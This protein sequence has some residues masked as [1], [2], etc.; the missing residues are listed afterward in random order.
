[1]KKFLLFF[2]LFVSMKSFSQ[3]GVI[4][5][6]VKDSL[7]GVALESATVTILKKDSSLVNYQLSDE[8]GSFQLTKLPV[9]T[10]LILNIT[11]AGF[12]S[13]YKN[14][15]L[16]S[17]EHNMTALL[18]P[19]FDDSLNVTVTAQ[20]PI[21]MNG[22]TL[23]IN[24]AA[25][26]MGPN[27][28]VEDLLTAVPGITV[29]SDGSITLNGKKIPS[30]LVDGKPFMGSDDARI[31]TQNL[32]KD[33]IDKIQVYQE[34]D[35]TLKP[36]ERR[37]KDSLLTMNIKLK[38]N[39][40]T[41]YFGKAAIGYGTTDRFESDLSF[42]MY[43]KKTSFGIGGGYNNINK[44]IENLKEMFQNN[45]YRNYNPNLRN[46]GNFNTEGINRYHSIG[47]AFT[48]N[49]IETSN[50]RQNDRITVNYTKSGNNRYL[51][52]L[53]L[54]NRTTVDNPQLIEDRV[55]TNGIN[56][57]HNVGINYIKTNSYS[58]NFTINASA[59][60]SDNSNNTI[61]NT[62]IRDTTNSMISRNN[63]DS[64]EDRRSNGQ[65]LSL[66][67]SKYSNDNPLA[68]FNV[69]LNVNNNNNE[70]E[71][72]V[73]SIFQSLINRDDDT[74]YNRR[75]S[76]N[77]SNLSI[78]GNVGYNGLKRLLFGRFNFFGIDLGLDQRFGYNK[79]K[80]NDRVF[81]YDSITG[82]YVTNNR[83]T[84][85]NISE[86]IEYTPSLRLSK[87]AFKWADTYYHNF[88]VN[89]TLQEDFKQDNNS[90]SFAIRNLSR[91]FA[92]FRYG[93]GL[94]YNYNR[95]EHFYYYLSAG[96]NKDFEY[97]QVDQLYTITDDVDVFNVRIGNPNLKNK[98]NHSYNFYSNFNSQNPKSLYS[99]NGGLN[100]NYVKSINPVTDS[101]INESSGKRTYYYINA[102][103]SES[104]NISYNFNIS[105]RIKKSNLQLM[106]NGSYNS[107]R[108]PNYIDNIFSETNTS[109]FNNNIN[110]Q[111]SL[112]SMII[113]NLGKM[114]GYNRTTQSGAG[115]T[116]FRNRSDISRIGLTVNLPKNY[117]ISSTLDHTKNTGL[118]KPIVLWNAF[119]SCRVL[120]NQQ[121]ELKFSAMDI[122]KQFQNVSNTADRFGT[123]TRITNGLQQ[124]FMLTFAYY[125]RKF[126]K[127]E[128]KRREVKEEW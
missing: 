111:F 44:N 37:Q 88:N 78:G 27:A 124:Y 89:F 36:E 114:I 104:Y 81:D 125:P 19:A 49:F 90:S 28:V 15:Q 68:Q 65:S 70:S 12:K 110:L 48:H 96:Y 11:Y 115:L 58:D 63:V 52:N 112:R 25:F 32:P 50:S 99:F 77:S 92:F 41:G 21:R 47:G 30:V 26:K 60:N 113:F 120:K 107:N 1:M 57:N 94:S 4:K 102:Q 121:G 119:A 71:R 53:S 13:F 91:S 34:V 117:T 76:N 108:N 69:N 6:T 46:V 109:G 97:A 87:S 100:G 123:T 59:N 10:D 24:P 64:R 18:T 40:Q 33:A 38:E 14:L 80:R 82:N 20:V 128:V 72:Y 5:G 103:Q 67:Y 116:S 93:G 101:L 3:T 55:I 54:Q 2:L 98:V 75:Y 122:L 105:R 95:R 126:G 7:T 8:Y 79:S 66:N 84:N 23:E 73:K 29:W 17:A 39:K 42:Q 62:D 74:S 9:K 16:D 51:T 22:D 56:N 31:A 61:R 45:T 85:N 35:R 86:K 43:N 127:T 83:L 118:E 106:Y